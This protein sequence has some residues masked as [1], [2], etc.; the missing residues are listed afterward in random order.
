ML[1]VGPPKKQ[2]VPYEQQWNREEWALLFLTLPSFYP[3]L[4]LFLTLRTFYPKLFA[5]SD[6]QISTVLELVEAHPGVGF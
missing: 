3:K 1:G 5:R 2:S 6:E 4:L